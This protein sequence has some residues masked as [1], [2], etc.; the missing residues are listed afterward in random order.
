MEN[1]F[2]DNDDILFQ[3]EHLDL[4][5][6]ITYREDNFKEA[7]QFPYAPSDA[8]DARD[9]YRKVLEIIG[10]ISG[11]TLAPLAADIDEEG[12]VLENGEVRYAKGTK[13]VLDMF[14]KADLMGFCMPRKYGG[15][16][17]PTIMLTIAGEI[18]SRADASFLNFG[19]QQDIGETLNKFGSEQQ[20]AEVLPKLTSGEWGSSMI[21][22]EPD[23]GS[24]LQAVNLRAHQDEH[25]NWFLNGVK[26]FIT[27][28]NG[29]VGLVLA[30]SEDGQTGAR[31]L[32][33]F[34]YKRDEH[35][36][37]R[38]LEHKLGIHGSPTCELQFTN[39]PAT[40]VGERR[41]GLTKYT[42]WLMN[43]ARL[44][45]ASQALGIAE[46][47]YREADKYARERIQFGKT[48]RELPPVYE[49]LTE[50]RVGIE[51]GRTLL[52][53]T[54]IIVD[55]KEGLE[56]MKEKYPER[57][58]E[59]NSDLKKYSRLANLL[60]PMVKAYTTELANK[61]AYDGIQIH[62]G[63]GY[64]KDFNAERHYRDARI[65]N[66]YEGTTQ[67]QIVAAI[68]GVTSGTASAALDEYDEEAY[69]YA[70]ELLK[71][72][73][74]TRIDYDK[75]LIG[76]RESEDEDFVTFH[77][78]RCVEM[79][80]DLVQG[81]LLLRDAKHSA[82]KL[83]IA[84]IFI[85]KMQTRIHMNMHYILDGGSTFLKNYQDVLG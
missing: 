36:K 73:R 28:G 31:G 22:T 62:G 52:Y 84:E 12:V 13:Q 57:A 4:D 17:F 63:P 50:M 70:P 44:G 51:A 66:I 68:G 67:L 69:S 32:S 23:A 25:G 16:N 45:I 85:E 74:K 39:A 38:R 24:D 46:A 37:I 78:R 8:V 79:A 47:A 33:F 49:M 21:L 80:T 71:K 30:R 58:G 19:L 65:T 82:R 3:L 18:V 29:K 54:A 48:I 75:A 61:V 11:E 15:L 7:D 34:L 53:E 59:F 41:R 10:E 35:M 42:M 5:R 77:S 43:S 56:H 26:R 40:L 14:G 9:S 1:Y 27:N 6:V 60:T 20:K 55:L 81:Y 83:R 76:V 72:L 64:M 2:L